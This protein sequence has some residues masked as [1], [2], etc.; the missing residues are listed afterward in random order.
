M[1]TCNFWI[2]S[3]EF[4]GIWS[5]QGSTIASHTIWRLCYQEES[6]LYIGK[7][8]KYSHLV[9]DCLT[10]FV[11]YYSLHQW[12]CPFPSPWLSAVAVRQWPSV[13]TLCPGLDQPPGHSD[14]GATQKHSPPHWLNHHQGCY[15]YREWIATFNINI[16]SSSAHTNSKEA[17]S[18][19]DFA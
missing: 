8:I 14:E 4:Y 10:V 6:I 17:R 16:C 19:Y 9:N 15:G 1:Y 2:E 7:Q 18:A 11:T 5:E 12:Q 13:R 3:L